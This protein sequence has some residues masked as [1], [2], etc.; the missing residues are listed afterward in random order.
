VPGFSEELIRRSGYGREG[1][2][3]VYDSA[4]PSPPQT[5]LRALCTLAG[6][7]RPRLVVDL[8]CGTGLSTR[9]WTGLA[10]EVVGIE[11]NEAMRVVAE[12]RT[13]DASVRYVEG[14]GSATGLADASADI[15]TCAQS[16]HWMEPGPT[17]AEAARI[18]RAGGVFAAYDYDVP[19][20]VNPEVD[21]AFADYLRRR[22]E[23][24][25]R[26]GIP[27]G[28]E[29]W[30]KREHLARIEASDCFSRVRELVLH[31]ETEGGA[32]RVVGLARSIGPA[33]E[34][35]ETDELEAAARRALGDRVVPWLVGYRVRVG[36]R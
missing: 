31:D 20:L 25:E 15:V 5:L 9:A 33:L 19:P 11:P 23:L 2:A 27:A 17:L 24:R 13:A 6:V 29:R 1:F 34:E 30:P 14:F 4:R 26:L 28:V 35:L 36:I 3:D 7:D 10:D 12:A 18:L 8:G 22:R 16:F 32:E 21:Q